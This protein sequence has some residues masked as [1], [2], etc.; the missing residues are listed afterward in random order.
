ME[1]TECG[2]STKVSNSR[3]SDHREVT[4]FQKSLFPGREFILRHRECK[5]CQHTHVTYEISEKVLQQFVKD[6]GL[7]RRNTSGHV[8]VSWSK[9]K[10]RWIAK[11]T[12]NSITR[13]LGEFHD[14]DDAIAARKTG[15]N[16]NG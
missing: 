15:G 9:S 3:A 1:C 8:G 6:K 16:Q 14:I 11:I 12:A 13:Y 2:G 10:Q 4:K 5:D 7:P